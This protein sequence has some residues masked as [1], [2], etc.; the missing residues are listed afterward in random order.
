VLKFVEP[1]LNPVPLSFNP[2]E[3]TPTVPPLVRNDVPK[4]G[5]PVPRPGVAGVITPPGAVIEPRPEVVGVPL[6]AIPVPP[7]PAPGCV[8]DEPPIADPG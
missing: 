4:F 7:S 1:M 2:G 6:P 8:T 5:V 3:P